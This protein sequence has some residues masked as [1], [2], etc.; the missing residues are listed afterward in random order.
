MVYNDLKRIYKT[1]E[2]QYGDKDNLI[3][4]RVL[5]D[6]IR[7][8]GTMV[9]SSET[10]I[11]DLLYNYFLVKNTEKG[12]LLE[13]IMNKYGFNYS[14]SIHNAIYYLLGNR[15]DLF[16]LNIEPLL[17]PG[18]N[19]VSIQSNKYVLD[20][21]LGTIKVSKA[22]EVLKDKS[23]SYIFDKPLM[24]RCF[25]RSYDVIKGNKNQYKV[26]LSYMPNFFAGGHYHAY[27]E[28]DDSSILDVAANSYYD[29]DS[30][31]DFVLNGR[32]IKKLNFYEIERLYNN[33]Y[34]RMPELKNRSKTKLLTLSLYYD[35]KNNG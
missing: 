23:C 3:A 8:G 4:R 31:S 14:M 34:K 17:W 11:N 1:N 12:K 19:H 13:S 22:S 35:Y 30:N 21:A 5:V 9:T 6:Y 7:S 26:V 15:Y 27:L 33:L 32:I 2:L 29:N 16:P 20:T 10:Y 18:V 24:G 25:E 28:S